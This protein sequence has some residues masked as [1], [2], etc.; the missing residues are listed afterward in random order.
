MDAYSADRERS[1]VEEKNA[2]SANKNPTQLREEDEGIKIPTGAKKSPWPSYN[3][4]II[5]KFVSTK[6]LLLCG[7]LV[8]ILLLI[9]YVVFLLLLLTGPTGKQGN[10]GP[11]GPAGEQGHRGATGPTGEQGDTGQSGEQGAAG[12][13]G[14]QGVTG[15]SGDQGA[16]GPKGGQ[17]A[18]GQNN[19]FIH[20]ARQSLAWSQQGF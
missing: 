13:T 8:Y 10:Q 6:E 17:G 3:P 20:Q 5:S 1:R 11:T 7:S 15:P 9:V 14:E 18:T 4:T 2:K 12:P 19:L 16:T